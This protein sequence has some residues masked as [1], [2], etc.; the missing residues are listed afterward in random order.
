MSSG[1]PIFLTL[2]YPRQPST[3]THMYAILNIA[4]LL[5]SY[6]T[7]FFPVLKGSQQTANTHIFHAMAK[8]EA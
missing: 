2:P 6:Q 4:N 1:A 7:V 5:S 3:Y 8:L